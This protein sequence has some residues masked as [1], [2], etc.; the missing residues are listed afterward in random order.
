MPSGR[1]P[2]AGYARRTQTA[3][4]AAQ[5]AQAAQAAEARQEAQGAAAAP[6][7]ESGRTEGALVTTAGN[8]DDGAAF[9]DADPMDEC[10]FVEDDDDAD[11]VHSITFFPSDAEPLTY[12]RPSNPKGALAHLW[13]LVESGRRAHK[14]LRTMERSSEASTS[15][16]TPLASAG[17]GQNDYDH[18]CDPAPIKFMT[19][20]LPDRVRNSVEGEYYLRID[21]GT[22]DRHGNAYVPN[23]DANGRMHFIAADDSHNRSGSLCSGKFP[24]AINME[25]MGLRNKSKE[26]HFVC[27]ASHKIEIVVRLFKHTLDG[28]DVPASEAEL[29][30]KICNAY[31]LSQRSGDD[32][33][34]KMGLYLSL[35][36]KDYPHSK[37]RPIGA[38]AL[39]QQPEG[40]F[41]LE[42]RE[43]PPCT[44]N[45]GIVSSY[46]FAMV[47]GVATIKFN[48]RKTTTSAN[49]KDKLKWGFFVLNVQAMNPYLAG[50]NGFS[51]TSLPFRIK[52]VM[53]NDV[54]GKDRYVFL[55]D[56]TVAKSP[57]EDA[58]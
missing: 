49:L 54:H 53:H 21:E 11:V 47:R 42:P 19:K 36:F 10:D 51:V 27:Y 41:L 7:P 48:L 2:P 52:S 25:K 31:P 44:H 34:D 13:K 45:R 33:A 29:L 43:S 4:E 8:H 38:N 14:K 26:P 16:T 12:K 40:G 23:E 20:K 56:G 46:E 6:A 58:R 55:D 22:H 32:L 39:K 17:A 3:T 57:P 9:S 37:P 30:N 28:K 15:L 35:Q 1:T 18:S 50:L 5:A 24:H